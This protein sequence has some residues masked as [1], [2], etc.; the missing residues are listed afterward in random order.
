MACRTAFVSTIGLEGRARGVRGAPSATP[1][2]PSLLV[3]QGSHLLA[4]LDSPKQS[5]VAYP[6]M[7]A[8]SFGPAAH[9]QG[10]SSAPFATS[11][12]P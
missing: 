9:A 2:N 11:S 7:H 10:V 6:A 12:R 5:R 4:R 8:S 1:N 3:P